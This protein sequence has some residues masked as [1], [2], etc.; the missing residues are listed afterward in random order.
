MKKILNIIKLRG[1]CNPDRKN[2]ELIGRCSLTREDEQI[3]YKVK[4]LP[5]SLLNYIFCFGH[6]AI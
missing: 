5:Q 2:K 1:I 4:Q 3:V 6:Y